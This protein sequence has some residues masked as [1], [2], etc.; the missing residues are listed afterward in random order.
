MS[1]THVASLATLGLVVA[2]FIALGPAPIGGPATYVVV[3]GTSM[4]PTFFT[5]DLAVVRHSDSY[6]P[7]DI[8]AFRPPDAEPTSHGLV[9]H[10]IVGGSAANGFLTQ[11]DNRQSPDPWR[12]RP[13]DIVGRVWF[14]MPHVGRF[15]AQ[16]REPLV[17]A[18]L[19]SGLTVFLVLLGGGRRREGRR[20]DDDRT[21]GSQDGDAQPAVPRRASPD[22]IRMSRI[23]RPSRSAEDSWQ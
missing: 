20:R 16:L 9:I 15:I 4:Q 14:S 10:R 6:D 21:G 18:P 22:R 3:D 11:G 19:A 13:S 17:V 23:N 2:W 1:R 8:V 7:G 5:G 12:T